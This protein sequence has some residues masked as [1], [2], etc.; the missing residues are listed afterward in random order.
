[1]QTTQPFAN[2]ACSVLIANQIA[3]E[4]ESSTFERIGNALF[5]IDRNTYGTVIIQ[6][7]SMTSKAT[8]TVFYDSHGECCSPNHEE[9][10]G[11]LFAELTGGP[12]FITDALLFLRDQLASA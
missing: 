4:P 11:K 2:L 7:Y 6:I 8:A 9:K 1:M 12:S 5:E 10:F 3:P